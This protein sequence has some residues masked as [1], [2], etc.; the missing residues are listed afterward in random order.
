M[1]TMSQSLAY[2][3]VFEADNIFGSEMTLFTWFRNI[4]FKQ[5]NRLKN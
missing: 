5:I 3:K 4:F 1:A 2:K